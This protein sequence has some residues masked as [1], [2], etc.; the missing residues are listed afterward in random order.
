ML[1]LVLGLALALVAALVAL[2]RVR[3]APVER[4]DRNVHL[5]QIF[6][7]FPHAL[8]LR[9]LDGR[10][11]RANAEFTRLF[12]YSPGEVV[13]VNIDRLLGV[14]GGERTG[15]VE[16]MLTSASKVWRQTRRRRRDGSVIEVSHTGAPLT[17]NGQ[18]VA[19]YEVYHDLTSQL[20]AEAMITGQ[21][22]L[23]EAF[24][25]QSL[26]GFFFMMLDQPIRWSDDAD[27]DALIEYAWR[28]HRITRVNGAMLSQY[29]FSREQMLGL[30]PADLYAHDPAEGR[31]AWRRFFDA[32]RI[33]T[34]T[35][36]RR[37]DGTPI[38]IEG[39]YV[40]LY[41]DEGRI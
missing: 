33:H 3:R 38:L 27:K 11:L 31:A 6:E 5:E 28:H 8:T 7:T 39:D 24:F 37:A 36:E 12:Q 13:G 41:D 15:A 25:T 18:P 21:E 34:V 32:G 4:P 26:D 14:P 22:R 29:G 20:R 19:L 23:L 16:R 9:S 1:W 2:A 17:Q 30:T 10:L 40:C 35:R